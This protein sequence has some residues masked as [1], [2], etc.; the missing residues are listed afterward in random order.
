[1]RWF[2]Y[3]LLIISTRLIMHTKEAQI[4]LE[5]GKVFDE[6][7][8]ILNYDNLGIGRLIYQLPI[9]LC[10]LFLQEVFKKGGYI[11]S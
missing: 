5:V 10:E 7:K 4:A 6:E 8:Y 9:K 2:K 3:G 11:N 1:M